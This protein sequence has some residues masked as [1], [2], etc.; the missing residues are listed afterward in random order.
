MIWYFRTPTYVTMLERVE[1]SFYTSLPPRYKW[2]MT[3]IK[4][5]EPPRVGTYFTV[6]PE[7]DLTGK[8]ILTRQEYERAI[9]GAT[10]LPPVN[11]TPTLF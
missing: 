4:L 5:G 11:V 1:G 9:C 6:E 8:Q 2:H 3:D 7:P 10:D